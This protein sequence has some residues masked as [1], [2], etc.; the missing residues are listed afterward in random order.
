MTARTLPG[1]GLS[2][3]WDLHENNWKDGMDAN[4]LALSA[5]VPGAVKSATTSLPGSPTNGDIYIVPSSASSNANKIAVRDNGTWTYFTPWTGMEMY[6]VDTA[7]RL[8]WSGSAWA[9]ITVSGSALVVKDEGSNV[10]T[11]ATSFNFV[12]SG[13]TATT[14]GSGHATVT[15]PGATGSTSGASSEVAFSAPPAAS[16]WIQQNFDST[17]THITDFTSPVAGVRLYEDAYAYGN[18]NI[19]RAAL[20][21]IPGTRWDVKARLRRHTRLT[22]FM[23]WGLV[24]RDSASGRSVTLG[25]DYEASGV[26]GLQMTA[27][28]TYSAYV[29]FGG[30]Q[31]QWQPN[32]WFRASYDGTDCKFYHSFDGEYWTLTKKYAGTA[33][34]G[35]LTNPATHVGFGYNANNSGGTD[36][37]QELDLLSWSATA[38]A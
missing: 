36:L 10:E 24:L 13:V 1:L 20:K 12:G 22:A 9:A 7:T 21:A 38:L 8:R 30:N 3:F 33:L 4:L 26:G 2:G 19:L 35:F 29:S 23:A 17:K 15:I 37:G 11:A 32:I 18:T 27:D 14:D 28:T 34:W 16:T 25:F 31:M 5:L 6:V